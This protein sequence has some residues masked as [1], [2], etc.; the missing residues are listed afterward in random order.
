MLVP[1]AQG[2]VL[3][4]ATCLFLAEFGSGFGVMVL[5]IAGGSLTAS[6]IPDTLRS[7]VA[8]ASRLCN[9]G[10]RPIGALAGGWLGATIGLRPSLWI[11]TLGALLG[12]MWVVP[13]RILL[14][15]ITPKPSHSEAQPHRT[16]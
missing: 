12:L 1:L 15:T 4:A 13:S 10:V 9:Y 8:G 7:R 5:D 3:F 16:P 14:R 2:P 6:L 11:A